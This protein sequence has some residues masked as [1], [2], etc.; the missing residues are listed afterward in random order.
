MSPTGWGKRRWVV[1]LSV[2]LGL[3][4][5]AH[6]GINQWTSNGPEGGRVFALVID[7]VNPTTLYAGTC[8]NGLF[9]STNG[10]ANWTA[11]TLFGDD[12]IHA[13][14]I[15]PNDSGTVYAGGNK[16]VFKS[17]DGGAHWIH[18]NGD[19]PVPANALAIDP[20][21]PLVLYGLANGFDSAA[22]YKS[23]DGGATW[24]TSFSSIVGAFGLPTIVI[25]PHT[26]T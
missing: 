20:T 5:L 22:I 18:T 13:V 21:N 16:G 24:T 26:P 15:T 19:G 23:T 6:A 9:K 12:C 14:A 17:T 4:N 11:L 25:D 10:G 7:P 3:T 2:A 1:I 8:G